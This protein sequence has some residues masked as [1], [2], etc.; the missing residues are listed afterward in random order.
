MKGLEDVEMASMTDAAPAVSAEAKSLVQ[1]DQVA[2][3]P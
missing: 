2:P 1:E 3:Q